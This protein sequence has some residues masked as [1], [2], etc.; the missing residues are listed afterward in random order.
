V[1]IKTPSLS[2]QLKGRAENTNNTLTVKAGESDH[3]SP[4]QID[5]PS[6]ELIS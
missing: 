5:H 2:D 1:I 6:L 4:A 3:Y